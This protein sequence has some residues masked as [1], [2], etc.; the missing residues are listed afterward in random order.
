MS[1]ENEAAL[2]PE[3]MRTQLKLMADMELSDLASENFGLFA[4]LV[5]TMNML[6]PEGYKDMF[7]AFTFQ[8]IQE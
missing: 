6:Q 8:P 4:G 7:P 2:S 3:F 5:V 1:Q